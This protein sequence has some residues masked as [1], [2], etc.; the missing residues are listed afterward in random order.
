[1]HLQKSPP[2]TAGC[3]TL[4]RGLW[5]PVWTLS[6][7]AGALESMTQST[8]LGNGIPERDPA[9]PLSSTPC[10]RLKRHSGTQTSQCDSD[11]G[12]DVLSPH[13]EVTQPR[14][15]WHSAWNCTPPMG[16]VLLPPGR[17]HALGHRRSAGHQRGSPA[18]P[19]PSCTPEQV[20]KVRAIVG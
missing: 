8:R 16:K 17:Q 9:C 3:P 13:R 5:F 4:S 18:L 15:A 20:K 14:T 2:S 12:P 7:G 10:P 1:M 11:R 6:K 19:R